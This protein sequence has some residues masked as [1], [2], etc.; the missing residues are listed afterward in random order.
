M[1]RRIRLQFAGKYYKSRYK[2]R[3]F[4]RFKI[5]Q[6]FV[7]QKLTLLTGFNFLTRFIDYSVGW[8]R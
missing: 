8:Y 5:W 1:H 6:R 4:A 3:I 7:T 2:T